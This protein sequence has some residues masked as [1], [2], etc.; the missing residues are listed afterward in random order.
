MMAGVRN[1]NVFEWDK[2][3]QMNQVTAPLSISNALVE[4]LVCCDVK[5]AS[6]AKSFKIFKVTNEII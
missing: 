6:I 5:L 1:T 3:R 2:L 4:L